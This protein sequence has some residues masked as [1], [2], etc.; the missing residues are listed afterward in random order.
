MVEVRSLDHI[1]ALKRE[2]A[3]LQ[4]QLAAEFAKQLT[5]QRQLAAEFAKQL[6]HLETDVASDLNGIKSRTDRL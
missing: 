2:I 3:A 4:R 6:T 5:L 1:A